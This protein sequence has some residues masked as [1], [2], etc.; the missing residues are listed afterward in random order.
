MKN[1]LHGH[2]EKGYDVLGV[3]I[4]VK[5]SGTIQSAFQSRDSLETGAGK[6]TI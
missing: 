3:F 6:V 5:L 1:I 2:V 4:S